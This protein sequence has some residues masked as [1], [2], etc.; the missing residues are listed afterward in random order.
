MSDVHIS[1][2]PF[3]SVATTNEWRGGA[4]FQWK[5]A[6]DSRIILGGEREGNVMEGHD[7]SL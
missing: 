5:K 7:R 4:P 6:G 2:F 3:I 1:F